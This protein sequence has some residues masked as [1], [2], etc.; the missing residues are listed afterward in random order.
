MLP[1]N[2]P[3]PTP[4]EPEVPANGTGEAPAGDAPAP[5]PT[6]PAPAEPAPNPEGGA[7]EAPEG[8]VDYKKKFSESTT[9]ANR[10][11]EALKAN[12]IDPKTGKKLEAGAE[13]AD[14]KPTEPERADLPELS[15]EE[16]ETAF[17]SYQMLSPQEKEVIK[18]VQQLPKALRM[19]AEMHDQFTTGK[20]IEALKTKEGYEP[21]GEHEE[22]FRTFIYKEENLKKDLNLL[23]DSFIL[24]K[25]REKPNGGEPAPEETTPEGMEGGTHGAGTIGKQTGD[26]LEVTQEE[27]ERLRK[28]DPRRYNK[29]LSQ[30][31]LVIA[32]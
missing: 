19:V 25:M 24:Q 5:E 1:E 8:D 9:E 31:K 18:N 28:E 21:I 23:A 30:K 27:A 20:Q 6:N 15:E 13:G 10:L 26:K 22:E 3:N 7:G 32:N 2:N 14:P 29:L 17:P 11:L 16:L 12:G 4:T